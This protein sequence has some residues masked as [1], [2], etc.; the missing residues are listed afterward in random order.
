VQRV[1]LCARIHT[2]QPPPKTG[3]S[4]VVKRKGVDSLRPKLLDNPITKSCAFD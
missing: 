4:L 2:P 1:V 3:S